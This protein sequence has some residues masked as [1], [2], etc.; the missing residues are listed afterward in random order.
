MCAEN[1][2]FGR[3]QWMSLAGPHS[4]RQC[5]LEARGR[6]EVAARPEAAFRAHALANPLRAADR[7]VDNRE[8]RTPEVPTWPP[9]CREA[10]RCG[11]RR[12]YVALTEQVQLVPLPESQLTLSC[13]AAAVAERQASC[14]SLP[15]LE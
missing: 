10:S 2:S 6:G 5:P 4:D 1:R 7:T 9:S 8:P 14:W 12:K 13:S 11:Y 3:S 15:F